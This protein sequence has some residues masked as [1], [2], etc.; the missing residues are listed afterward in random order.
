VFSFSTEKECVYREDSILPNIPANYGSSRSVDPGPDAFDQNNTFEVPG[1]GIPKP[2]PGFNYSTQ[3]HL[4]DDRSVD[5]EV[6]INALQILGS[7]ENA[8]SSLS[9]FF[10]GTHQRISA[11]CK[12]RVYKSLPTLITGPRADFAV[13]CVCIKLIQQL[14]SAQ[15]TDMQSALYLE[16]KKLTS[17][18]EATSNLSLD[19]VHCKLLL[20]FYELGH[21]LH[22]SAYISIAACAR[23]ARAIGLHRKEWQNIGAGTDRLYMEEEKRTWWAVVNMERFI[24]LCNGEALLTTDDPERSDPLPIEDLA[25]LDHPHPANIEALIDAAPVLATPSSIT[26]GQMA[27]ES[28][29]SHLAGRVVRHVFTP[30]SDPSFNT[31]EG[32]QLERT[33]KSFFPLLADEELRVGNYCGAL[34]ICN[35]SVLKPSLTK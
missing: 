22:R 31:E 13:L 10:I 23:V 8:Q 1:L 19:V 29:V 16:V 2:T 27:R 17:L 6:R 21:A 20:T 9:E 25:W 26:V 30:T 4:G 3:E 5:D 32:I 35:R 15:T 33:L 34:G 12:S 24:N 28:Q 14:P 7:F 11:L 18:L